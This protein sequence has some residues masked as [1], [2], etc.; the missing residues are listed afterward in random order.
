MPSIRHARHWPDKG[1]AIRR[2]GNGAVDDALDPGI[3][4]DRHAL[5]RLFQPR[6]DPVE[7]PLKQL[8]LAGPFR[9][10]AA[11][12]PSLP[13]ARVLVNADETRLLLLPIIAR[14]RR[15]AHHGQFDRAVLEL[16]QRFGDQILVFHIGDRGIDTQPLADLSG[17][18]ARRIDEMLAGDIALFSLDPELA[19]RQTGDA[20]H[21][22]APHNSGA[23]CPRARRHGIART[24]RVH[25]TVHRGVGACQNAIGL[26]PG[27]QLTDALGADDFHLEPNIG[28]KTLD[29]AE[30]VHL[31][32]R[33]RDA[34]AAA[35][36]PACRMARQLLKLGVK[37]IPIMV[38]LGHVVIANEGR[39]LPGGV[40]SRT[41]GQLA[42]LDQ[43]DIRPPGFSEVVGQTYPH[44]ATADDHHLRMGLHGAL[45]TRRRCRLAS[46]RAAK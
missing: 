14:C 12:G 38:D 4:E 20:R 35:A 41:A 10:T 7:I 13:R 40:P 34:D 6:G 3:G 29:I 44:H 21:A 1:V 23:Q 15:I 26:E 5:Q 16:S 46:A 37:R 8:I 30:P 25:M 42:L 31:L 22:V 45:L 43:Q 32:C 11:T 19:R 36:V 9:P 17:I 2:V 39:A 24:R 27:V 18:T 28:G 33:G